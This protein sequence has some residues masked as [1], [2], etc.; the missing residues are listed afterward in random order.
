VVAPYLLRQG[1]HRLDLLMLSHGD[2]DHAGGIPA[3]RKRVQVTREI[4]T[5]AGEPC[6]EGIR[7]EWDGVRFET[8]H[9]DNADWS[10]NNSSCVLRMEGAFTALLPGDIEAGAEKRL[11]ADHANRLKSDVLIAPHH[12]SKTSSTENFVQAVKPEVVLYGA[13]WRNHFSHPRPE[14]VQRYSAIGAQQ[15]VT[16]NGGALSVESTG[17]QLNVDVWRN[18]ARHFWNAYAES[19]AVQ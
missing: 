5:D 3:V 11:L 19:L 9:P 10:R 13:G 12:G 7:W 2:N 18:H 16:G 17:S 14:V 8:L 15:F 6:R 4:G 1:I